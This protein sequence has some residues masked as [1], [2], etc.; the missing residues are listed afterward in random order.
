MVDT[1]RLRSPLMWDLHPH[2]AVNVQSPDY[3][4]TARYNSPDILNGGMHQ[5][6][7]V[8]NFRINDPLKAPASC[9]VMGLKHSDG[10]LGVKFN[11]GGG[12][13][14]ELWH[15]N[16]VDPPLNK[17]ESVGRGEEIG[18]TGNTGATLPDGSPMPG[19]V[20]IELEL[21]GNR[22]DP[23]PYLRIVGRTQVWIQGATY[24]TRFLDV[25]REHRFYREIEQMGLLGVARG[26][27]GEFN[28]D[29]NASKGEVMAFLS[30][31]YNK[32]TPPE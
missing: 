10:A 25:Q 13:A 3:R 19:H 11:L 14:F 12:W 16:R 15:L 26:S 32:L 2:D 31:L 29:S 22:V 28:P 7:D 20:H 5:A 21:N 8:G 18:L 24:D 1:L 6:V 9:K 4:I 23:E 27:H 30:R 17:W